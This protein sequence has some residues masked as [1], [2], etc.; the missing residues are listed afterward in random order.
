MGTGWLLTGSA[1]S[2]LDNLSQAICY[3][4]TIQYKLHLCARQM[5]NINVD[6]IMVNWCDVLVSIRGVGVEH[7]T[8]GRVFF[9][10]RLH[11]NAHVL[12]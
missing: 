7:R 9:T 1:Q 4:I 12:H 2:D 11:R 3:I 8:L 10:Y 6:I 5:G